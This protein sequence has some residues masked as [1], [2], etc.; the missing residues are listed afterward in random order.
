MSDILF[1][2]KQ[3]TAY[4]I[5]KRD[6]SSDVCSSDLHQRFVDLI[7]YR[8]D[9]ANPAQ[10]EYENIALA[11]AAGAEAELRIAPVHGVSA[12]ANYTWLDTKVLKSGFDQS[13]FAILAEG[14]PLLRRPNT[15][16]SGGRL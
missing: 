7:D 13:P 4:E 12:D 6:W 9:V 8:Y 15:S 16:S 1:F 2:F 10:S 11:R 14:H 5:P 3:K